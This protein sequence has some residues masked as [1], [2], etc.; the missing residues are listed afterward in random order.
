MNE[1]VISDSRRRFTAVWILPLVAVVAGV[2]IVIHSYLTEG[3]EVRVTFSTAEGLK[4]GETRVKRLSVELGVVSEVY[5][6]EGYNDVTAVIKLDGGSRDLLRQDS[7][8]WV[9]R[10]RI[11]ASGVSGLTALLSGAHVELSPGRGPAGR[12]EFRGLDDVPIT[13]LS[14]P[15]AHVKLVAA[16]SGSISVGSPVLYQG[17]RVGQVEKVGLDTANKRVNYQLFVEAP[18]NDL[19]N[20]HTRFWNVS[21]VHINA[22]IN[23]VSVQTESLEALIAGGV[24]FGLP[25]GVTA[26]NAVTSE[27]EFSLHPDYDSINEHPY[28]FYREFVLVFDSSIRG[29]KV[30]A[31]VEYRGI[32]IGTVLDLSLGLLPQEALLNSDGH[33]LIPALIR[34]DPGRLQDDSDSG[35]AELDEFIVAGVK[36]GLRASL[37]NGNLITGSL[38]VELDFHKDVAAANLRRQGQ[39][40][41]LPTT[42]TR[43]GQLQNQLA[44][45][46]QKLQELPIE[47]T[48]NSASSALDDIG[49]AVITADKTLKNVDV[50]LEHEDAKAL[51]TEIKTA[52]QELKTTLAGLSP[53]SPLYSELEL[54]LQ[55]LQQVMRNANSLSKTLDNKPSE[56]IFSSA[57]KKDIEPESGQ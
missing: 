13:P 22:G 11:G 8:F 15:G 46:L 23:G 49:R 55:D 38:Y 26:G 36:N 31:P 10:P 32:R 29:L 20:T 35:L 5:L 45:I 48:L 24:A 17:Y 7:Q 53:Q 44:A 3:P 6:N 54:A 21:G 42:E 50:I 47:K 41:I 12:R 39:Y 4:A 18:Y 19:I 25:N 14:T 43:L 34:I 28:E 51:P 37:A 30:G 33:A 1:A 40:T 56:L 2:W 57:R 27:S 9:V 16:K 52:L